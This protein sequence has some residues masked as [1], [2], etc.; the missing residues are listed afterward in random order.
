MYMVTALLLLGI[1]SVGIALLW[2]R[3][4]IAFG[5]L[6][7]YFSGRFNVDEI[8]TSGAQ[9]YT[10][11]MSHKWFMKNVVHGDYLKAEGTL[12]DFVAQNTL[13]GTMVIGMALGVLPVILVLV[14]F[15]S[16]TLAGASLGTVIIAVFIIRSPGEVE[17]SYDLLNHLV[18]Q[19]LPELE[20]GDYA[21]AKVA[22]NRIRSWIK[23]VLALGSVSIL[24]SP[25]GELIPEAVAFSIAAFFNFFVTYVFIPVA[26][27]SY[28]LALVLFIS[29][30]PFTLV[31]VY[32]VVRWIRI[33]IRLKRE[34]HSV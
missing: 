14:L 32:L 21:Y 27:F 6:F 30:V 17:V 10:N 8:D 20:K 24:V 3:R 34:E 31:L 15:Q 11:C 33:Q 7:I 28:P 23:S 2:H 13:V 29:G 18:D 12:G 9:K 25:W 19:D 1:L 5:E 16:F 22:S 4:L 26:D